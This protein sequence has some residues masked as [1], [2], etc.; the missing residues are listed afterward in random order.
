MP[1]LIDLLWLI[2]GLT[3]LY[4]GAEW[5]VGGASSLA[6]RFGISP[7]V[8]GLTVVAFGTSAPELFV[9]IGFNLNG[10]PG[11]A[12]G[13]VVGSNI[14]NIALVLGVSA[15]ICLL[16][17]KSQLIRLDL[18]VLLLSTIAFTMMLWNG[19]ISRM[20]GGILFAAV[21][22]YTWYRLVLTRK[23]EEPEVTEQFEEEF[24]LEKAE[25]DPVWKFSILILVGLVGL[26]FG[27]KWLE[28]GGVG[29]AEKMG[30]PKAV[31]S[32]TLIAFSTSVPELATS[33]IASLKKQ[34][35][36]I[37]GS[38]IGSCIFNLLSVIGITALVK[39]L[40]TGGIEMSDLY[41][42]IGL[43]VVLCIMMF[44]GKRISR[45]EGGLLLLG[46]AGYCTFLWFDR[47]A[48]AAAAS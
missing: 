16:Q 27:A 28:I 11:M 36:I 39:P 45:S 23:I 4:F 2:A 22:G 9:S 14:C 7:L 18:P 5:L 35:D 47:V 34:G 31:I 6:I 46:Y 38:V 37:T 40:Q 17:V 33:I 48:G 30:V 32:L 19:Q 1:V 24:D 44:T 20:E 21:L 42:M 43:T 15:F 13:N 26:Y 41:V 25:S 29:L 12:L 3:A 10:H 8:V